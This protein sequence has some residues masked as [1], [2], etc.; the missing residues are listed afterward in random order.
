M[1]SEA[2]LATEAHGFFGNALQ[3][4]S[5]SGIPFLVGGGLALRQYTGII[6]DL[7]DLDL[8]CRAVD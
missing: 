5:E 8:F 3:L 4:L 2:E 7:K 1:I 6:R